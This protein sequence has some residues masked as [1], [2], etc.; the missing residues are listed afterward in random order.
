MAMDKDS[1][2][3]KLIF[4][5]VMILI[6]LFVFFSV[7]SILFM[8]FMKLPLDT[9]MPWSPF[10][11]WYHYGDIPK[12]EK[13]L[14]QSHGLAG[15]LS[16][17]FL[18]V[19]LKKKK[20]SLFGE[21]KWAKES[22][23][24]N[25]DPGLRGKR[26]ILLGK[27]NG[28]YVIQEGQQFA[29]MAAPTRSMKGVGIV[30]P[31]CLNWHDSLIVT[32]IKLENYAITS[33][34]RREMGQEVFM[35]NPSPRDY[36]THR[37]NPLGYIS[38]DRN[39]R[40]DDIQKIASFLVPSPKGV[41]PMW[42]SEARDLFMGIVLL[43]L[44]DGRYPVTLGE[45]FRQL[46]TEKETAEY[47]TDVLKSESEEL[48]SN[49]VMALN[50]FCNLPSKQREGVK[51]TLTSA[52]NLWANPLLDAAT[53]ANDFDL[54]NIRRKRM[55][56]YVGITPDNLERLAPVLN[57]F[58][59]QLVD[60][61]TQALPDKEKDPYSVLLL[62]D[63]FPAL[64]EMK[65]ISKGVSYMA[66]YNLRLLPIVQSPSQLIDI[67]GKEGSDNFIENHATRVV[68]AP[69]KMKEAEEIANELGNL[70]V[71][72]ESV[73]KP[74]EMGK[75]MGNR[76]ISETKRQL[77]LPQ[78]IKEIGQK[79]EIILSENCRP[80]MAK[81]IIYYQDDN[82]L[83]R[84]VPA[85]NM[86]AAKK[87][88]DQKTFLTLVRPPALVPEIRVTEHEVRGMKAREFDLNFDSVPLP[89]T[90]DQPLSNDQ[91]DAAADDFMAML[92]SAA[93]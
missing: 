47:L 61:N 10:Q 12:V 76:T 3:F 55:T 36:M 42:S 24:K 32:D 59:Q 93:A 86:A 46:R 15:A 77:L 40:I 49:C 53:A 45:V 87:C 21:A 56:I 7:G 72:A 20:L 63:E 73:S 19:F 48:D 27:F 79:A 23:L 54:R 78:E 5:S 58:F 14:L 26:G 8:Q 34:F 64:G 80:I 68:Y 71:K 6:A 75:G 84:C 62:M 41:D 2:Q 81:K 52:L 92:Q 69:K 60:L 70:T 90:M 17:A 91:I 44:D 57:L 31:N 38:E 67:Y 39:F 35:F 16:F 74:R 22:D 83:K 43:L 33:G 85:E 50:K 30:I 4:Y 25:A 88:K 37:W 13:S 65:T 29:I 18:V 11:Y 82:F 1:A 51:S 66:G 89:D 28:R 9:A